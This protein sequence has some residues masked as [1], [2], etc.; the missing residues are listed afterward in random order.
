[1]VRLFF[2]MIAGFGVGFVALLAGLSAGGFVMYKFMSS[3]P[4][5]EPPRVNYQTLDFPS[6]QNKLYLAAQAWGVAGNHQ[7]VRLCTSPIEQGADGTCLKF[8]SSELFY[9]RSGENGLVVYADS[10]AIPNYHVTKLGVFDIK[11]HVLNYEKHEA[12]RRDYDR[13]G[14]MRISAP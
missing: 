11:I 6:S 13:R 3:R 9:G 4:W 7:E 12:M 8:Y 10:S 2:V 5:I 1:M 14:L